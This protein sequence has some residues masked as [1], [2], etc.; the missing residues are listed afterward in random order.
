MLSK[1]THIPYFGTFFQNNVY[2]NLSLAYDIIVNFIDAHEEANQQI[3]K[4]IENQ[5]FVSQILSESKKDIQKAE[6]Y[7]MEHIEDMFPEIAKAIQIRRAQ[8]YLLND[9]Y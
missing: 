3:T 1:L 5:H 6:V 4:I 8:Y 2:R 7:I 9:G